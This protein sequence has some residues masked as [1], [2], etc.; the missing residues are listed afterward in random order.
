MYREYSSV[1]LNELFVM[2][3][4]EKVQGVTLVSSKRPGARGI[5]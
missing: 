5:L 1:A 4:N 3:T 2:D